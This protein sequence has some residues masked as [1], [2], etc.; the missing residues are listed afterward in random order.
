MSQ[1]VKLDPT[2]CSPAPT[3][4]PDAGLVPPSPGSRYEIVLSRGF[5]LLRF[6]G[7]LERQYQRDEEVSRRDMMRLGGM[8][9]LLLTIGLLIPDWL[10]VP[11][12]MDTAWRLR[13]LVYSP[14]TLLWLMMFDRIRGVWREWF[15]VVMS[16]VSAWIVAWLCLHSDDEL[17]PA[18]FVALA[19]ILLFNSGVTRMRFWNA[20]AADLVILL[21][22]AVSLTQLATVPLVLMTAIAL[23]LVSTATFCLYSAYCHEREGR[24]NW[25]MLQHEHLLLAEVEQGNRRL[26]QLSRHDALTDLAN[27]RHV[28]EFLQQVWDRARHDGDEVAVLMMD[29]DHFKSYNDHYGHPEGDACLRD[30]AQTIEAHLRQPGDLVGRFGGEEFIAVLSRT[31]L[32]KAIIAGERVREGVRAMNRVHAASAT[33][34]IVTVSI[35]AASVRPG[36]HERS[37]E[38]LLALADQALYHAKSGGRDR[39]AALSDQG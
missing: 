28:D 33:D 7:D 2:A 6:P 22:Y 23:V 24:T 26:D 30:V 18:Y 38:R 3:S 15:G 32:G 12:T 21:V 31:P 27:R 14:P 34:A 1:A 4:D 8:L 16:S 20:L 5:P 19:M 29:I 17:A 39:V 37:P 10:M 25:L 11:D 13:L 35:G 36:R 9:A